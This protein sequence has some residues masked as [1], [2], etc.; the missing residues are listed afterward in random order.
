MKKVAGL[1]FLACVIA[2]AASSASALAQTSSPPAKGALPSLPESDALVCLNLRRILNEALPRVLPEKQLAEM[3]SGLD[4]VKQMSGIDINGLDNAVLALRVSKA[5]SGLPTPDLLFVVRGAFNADALL[6]LMRMGLQGKYQEEKYGTKTL[7]T[8]KISDLMKSGDGK[9]GPAIPGVS[10]ISVAALDA[11]T[12][13]AGNPDYLKAAIDSESGQKQIKP[14]LAA[15]AT[16]D[17]GALLSVAAIIPPGFLS[18]L[19]PKEAQGNE[20]INKLISGIDQV[21]LS[22]GMDAKDFTLILAIRTASA[23]HA[24]TLKG[25]AEMG[26]Q[27]LGGSVQDKAL[28]DTLKALSVTTENTEV[29]L[30]TGVS[31]EAVAAFI[32][33]FM[34]P[35][36]KQAAP[37]QPPAKQAEKT[38]PK[39]TA[40]KPVTKP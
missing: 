12:L 17:P 9:S 38:P 33:N 36:A 37:Q 32:R 40:K 25:L 10:E 24:R 35:P 16:R 18:G 31:Q 7:T 13:A 26:A 29:Q 34:Q 20:E 6:S 27:G 30:R 23:D 22:L 28:Q 8:L 14:E 19:L 3:R 15:L 2:V 39:T 1:R 4:K 11:G 5:S 21:Y